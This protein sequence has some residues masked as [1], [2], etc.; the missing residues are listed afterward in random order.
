[1]L[2][3]TLKIVMPCPWFE[4]DGLP[5]CLTVRSLAWRSNF[6]REEFQTLIELEEQNGAHSGH[7]HDRRE[8]LKKASSPNLHVSELRNGHTLIHFTEK[9]CP[10]VKAGLTSL[11]TVSQ[12]YQSNGTATWRVLTPNRAVLKKMVKEIR[13]AGV[14]ISVESVKPLMSN[15]TLTKK[16]RELLEIAYRRGFF[17]VPRRT[18]LGQLAEELGVSRSTLMESLR[19]AE[20]RIMRERFSDSEPGEYLARSN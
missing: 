14:N 18:T 13:V 11:Y 12:A 17:D 1:M 2:V 10:C 7:S 3:A 15:K 20:A 8:F 16:Q 6:D 19:R 5:P 9:L 4:S